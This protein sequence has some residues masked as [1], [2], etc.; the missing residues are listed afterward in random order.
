MFGEPGRQGVNRTTARVM[1]SDNVAVNVGTLM[2]KLTE[3]ELGI[4][5]I[6]LD[7][8]QRSGQE[9]AS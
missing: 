7:A 2:D 6:Q 3:R 9:V 8:T 1:L 4:A 5:R